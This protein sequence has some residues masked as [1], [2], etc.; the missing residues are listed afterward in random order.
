MPRKF[1]AL[2][3]LLFSFAASTRATSPAAQCTA[4]ATSCTATGVGA[5]QTVIVTVS[6]GTGATPAT[7]TDTF[8]LTYT[9]PSF[10]GPSQN[11]ASW[12]GTFGTQTLCFFYAHTGSNSGSDTIT[13]GGT[14]SGA[15]NVPVVEADFWAAADVVPSGSPIDN[16]CFASGSAPNGTSTFSSCS[17]QSTQTNDIFDYFI[18][19]DVIGSCLYLD[20]R[21]PATAN[22]PSVRD[23]T[24][25]GVCRAFLLNV[26]AGTHL[27]IPSGAPA[28]TTIIFNSFNASG[29][30]GTFGA[31]LLTL[32]SGATPTP[33]HHRVNMGWLFVFGCPLPKKLEE[34]EDEAA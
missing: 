16:W 19:M 24:A 1:L 23:T 34:I 8:G 9:V 18:E 5:G 13:T 6:Y 31:I 20:L 2:L 12:T 17:L 32:K 26:D 22:G 27:V 30:P 4:H 25:S 14:G 3:G 11:C 7:P 21:S 33:V 29:V 10:S 28:T 15:L